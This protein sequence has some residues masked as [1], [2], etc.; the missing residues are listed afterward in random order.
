M[1]CCLI[2]RHD[3]KSKKKTMLKVPASFLYCLA[4]GSNKTG[5]SLLPLGTSTLNSFQLQQI[6]TTNE[7]QDKNMEELTK[8]LKLCDQRSLGIVSQIVSTLHTKHMTST[9]GNPILHLEMYSWSVDKAARKTLP[10]NKEDMFS[11]LSMIR[12]DVFGNPVLV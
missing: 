5:I 1:R 11:M 12:V 4:T 8:Q 6:E 2:L 3:A 7:K 9:F 10:N